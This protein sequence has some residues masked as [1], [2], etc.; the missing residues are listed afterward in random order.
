MNTTYQ[1]RTI[2]PERE[3]S[4][5]DAARLLGV[6]RWTVYSYLRKFPHRLKANHSEDKN[7]QFLKGK[8]LIAFKAQGFPKRGRKRLSRR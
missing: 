2:H 3:Y 1:N 5:S 6:C 8:Q 7:R 4:I